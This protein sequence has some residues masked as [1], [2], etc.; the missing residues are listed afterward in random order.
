MYSLT[1]NEEVINIVGAWGNQPWKKLS[2]CPRYR[3]RNYI[4]TTCFMFVFSFSFLF[5][6]FLLMTLSFRE[7]WYNHLTTH[8]QTI[9]L[10]NYWT[11]DDAIPRLTGD[12]LLVLL[13]VKVYLEG[14]R[15]NLHGESQYP[16]HGKK[17]V[18]NLLFQSENTYILSCLDMNTRDN[19]FW[20]TAAVG[21]RRVEIV[22]ILLRNQGRRISGRSIPSTHEPIVQLLLWNSET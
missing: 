6:W 4:W 8:V 20:N 17:I 9:K 5:S 18:S 12:S 3:F 15:A 13:F 7:I 16:P 22:D 1:F 21:N 11:I 19:L 10:L 14:E 2:R